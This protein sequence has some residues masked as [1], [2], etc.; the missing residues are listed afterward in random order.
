MPHEP[1]PI[2]G[3]HIGCIHEKIVNAYESDESERNLVW[4]RQL[5]RFLDSLDSDFY[6]KTIFYGR[7]IVA[8]AKA[9]DNQYSP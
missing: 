7:Q 4:W 2:C 6:A 8:K 9:L 5:D 1:C 3:R